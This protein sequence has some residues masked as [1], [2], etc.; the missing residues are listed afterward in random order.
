MIKEDIERDGGGE[1]EQ[2]F[3]NGVL[4]ESLLSRIPAL[5]HKRINITRRHI[6]LRD[7]PF[8]FSL[9]FNKLFRF[10]LNAQRSFLEYLYVLFYRTR[11]LSF[12][13][14]G[15]IVFT[16]PSTRLAISFNAYSMLSRTTMTS[17]E[18]NNPCISLRQVNNAHCEHLFLL[19]LNRA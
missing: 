2:E 15:C 8:T 11:Q 9:S 10:F 1:H 7:I 19:S 4:R 17:F 16:K 3:S 18:V 14:A 13:Q 12:S 6:S 5:Y